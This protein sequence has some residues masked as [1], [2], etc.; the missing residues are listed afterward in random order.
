MLVFVAICRKLE[1]FVMIKCGSALGFSGVEQGWPNLNSSAS[2]AGA[3]DS[4]RH[5]GKQLNSLVCN[6]ESYLEL[7]P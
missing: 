5:F 1:N 3:P 2:F 6:N 7:N 4:L